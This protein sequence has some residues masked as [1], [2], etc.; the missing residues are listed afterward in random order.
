MWQ[1]GAPAGRFLAGRGPSFSGRQGDSGLKQRGDSQRDSLWQL[2]G[3]CSAHDLI[4][5]AVTVRIRKIELRQGRLQRFTQGE[6]LGPRLCG[7]MQL[8]G[9]LRPLWGFNLC[10]ENRFSLSLFGGLSTR[11]DCFFKA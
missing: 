7:M 9:L 3:I 6:F 4:L 8:V 11:A 5:L 2:C 1:P 10:H